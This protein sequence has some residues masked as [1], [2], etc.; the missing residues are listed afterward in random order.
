[1]RILLCFGAAASVAALLAASCTTN[2]PPNGFGGGGS[3]PAG[4]T[5]SGGGGGEG[6]SSGQGGVDFDGGEEGAGGMGMPCANDP[7]DDFDKDG[8]T[9]E[10]GDCNDCDAET[11]P[12]AAEVTAADPMKKPVDEDCDG[13]IDEIEPACDTGLAVDDEDPLSGARSVDLCKLSSGAGDWGVVSAQWVVAD[14][15]PP[16]QKELAAF[17]LGHG[18]LSGF[19]PNV[20]VRKGERL[21]ALSSGAARQPGEAGYK[22]VHGFDKLFQCNPP[23]GFPKESPA[24]PI[25]TGDPHDAAGLEIKVRTPSNAHGFSFDF[26][27]YTYEWPKYVCTEYND[28]FVAILSP[29]PKG[30]TDGNIS[31]DVQGN[32]VSVNN[33]F[34]DVCGCEGNPPGTCA[35][36][37]KTFPCA[38]GDVELIGTGFGFDTA[39]ED[40][41]ATSWLVTKA[42]APPNSEIVIRFSVYDSGDGVLDSTTL[43]DD[44]RWIADPGTLVGTIPIPK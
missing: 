32:P 42:P 39:L 38:L 40:H 26:D 20:K 1:M 9:E 11:N 24:C 28:F 36:G 17:H 30:Q 16:P 37:G 18:L 13:A 8:F 34:L 3:S 33:A 25:L 27:F 2:A 19:G 44:W 15:A 4:S 10:Q 22:D 12:N 41:G 35:A 31:F 7:A 21:L 6:G 43:I 29:T 14:G 5:A 23:Q